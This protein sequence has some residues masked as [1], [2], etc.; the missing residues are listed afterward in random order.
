VIT[1]IAIARTFDDMA[2]SVNPISDAVNGF[3]S[4][5]Y[6]ESVRPS[7]AA[8]TPKPNERVKLRAASL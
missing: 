4:C 7:Q 8:S 3:D 5:F 6:A 1:D 2:D